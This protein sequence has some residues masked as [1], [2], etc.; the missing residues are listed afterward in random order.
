M[1]TR[2]LF[3]LLL[4]LALGLPVVG[5]AADETPAAPAGASDSG[6]THSTDAAAADGGSTAAE[7][8]PL[9]PLGINLGFLTAQI[10][11]FLLVFG[12]LSVFLWGPLQR[13]LDKRAADAQKALEDAAVA[14]QAR[15]K[16]EE[17]A[18]K[19]R[20]QARADVQASVDQGRQRGEE[21]AKGIVTAA[22]AEA[23][24]IRADAS[25]RI[26]EERNAE[27]AQLRGQVAAISIAVAQ[28]LIG[29]ALDEKKQQKLVDEFFSKLPAGVK[30]VSGDVTVVSAMPLTDGEQDKVKKE[31]AGANVSFAV[32]PGILGGVIVRAGDRVVDGSVR[33]GLSDLA[34]R[35]N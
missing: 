7:I 12:L 4:V 21:V 14:A 18:E 33:S 8:S 27:L 24:K 30:G 25:T 9:A 32:E 3:V 26:T 29:E 2:L 1:R 19:I 5:Y 34:S 20:A 28:R 23:D 10:V 35:L 15:M 13:T 6:D 11:N 22:Q 31:L 16:A 17:E